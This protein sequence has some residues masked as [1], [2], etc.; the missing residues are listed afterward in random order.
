MNYRKIIDKIYN[1]FLSRNVDPLGI[2]TYFN[3]LDSRKITLNGFIK[4]ITSSNEYI[5]KSKKKL[6]KTFLKICSRKITKNE[7]PIYFD[8]LKKNGN[9]IKVIENLLLNSQ[10]FKQKTNNRDILINDKIKKLY[11]DLL[12]KNINQE[13]LKIHREKIIKNEMSLDDLEY[14]LLN[15]EECSKLVDKKINDW[16]KNLDK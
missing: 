15:S 13:S 5:E 16:I 4:I 14:E 12:D 6:N 10:E 2:Q 9:D 3:L 7:F 8:I 1:K 11:K